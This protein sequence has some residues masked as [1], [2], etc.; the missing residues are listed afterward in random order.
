VGVNEETTP[1]AGANPVYGSGPEAGDGQIHRSRCPSH[2][3]GEAVA[4]GVTGQIHT[5][6]NDASTTTSGR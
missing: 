6:V 5:E 1:A 3:T 2:S 4:P